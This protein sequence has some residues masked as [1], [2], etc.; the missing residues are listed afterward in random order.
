MLERLSLAIPMVCV[1]SNL[2]GWR[3]CDGPSI[4]GFLAMA[5]ILESAY[6]IHVNRF[7]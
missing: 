4:A 7:T 5:I 1:L 6:G 2:V 3:R